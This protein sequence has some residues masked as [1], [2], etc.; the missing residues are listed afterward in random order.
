MQPRMNLG[1]AGIA[2]VSIGLAAYALKE[3][4][5]IGDTANREP[6]MALV[7]SE[8][9]NDVTKIRLGR[10]EDQVEIEMSGGAWRLPQLADYQANQTTVESWLNTLG[11]LS[12]LEP[13]TDNPALLSELRLNDTDQTES[14]GAVNITL[15]SGGDVPDVDFLI[16]REAPEY[17]S[18]GK[19]GFYLRL[20]ASSQA[21]LAE[22]RLPT[23]LNIQEWIDPEILRV[24]PGD[25]RSITIAD[26]DNVPIQVTRQ[27]EDRFGVIEGGNIIASSIAGYDALFGLFDPLKT[28]E[29]TPQATFADSDPEF[30]LF[31]SLKNRLLI[32]ITVSAMEDQTMNWVAVRSFLADRVGLDPYRTEALENRADTLN[33][34]RDAWLYRLEPDAIATIA[35]AIASLKALNPDRASG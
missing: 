26:G 24:E 19:P 3:H 33:E 32:E 14:H 2:I 9:L 27:G 11:E 15:Q 6:I 12:I 23:S 7:R 20:Q 22:G 17:A 29:V 18:P 13:R 31:V 5:N 4:A 16:G 35:S 8:H 34:A 10:G 30:L 1:L 21:W 28:I 25:I